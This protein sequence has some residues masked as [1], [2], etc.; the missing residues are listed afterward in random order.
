MKRLSFV[1]ILLLVFTLL[2]AGCGTKDEADILKSLEKKMDELDGYKAN[3]LLSI[4]TG[5][6]PQ[7]YDVEI[8]YKE[9]DFYRIALNNKEREI[10]QI[11]LK[12]EDGVFVLTP[13]LNKSFR[14]QSDWPDNQGQVYLY[15][16]LVKS[17][18]DDGERKFLPEGNVYSFEVNA[19]YQN[20]NLV[21]QKIWLNEDGLTP[22]KVEIMDADGNVLVGLE[23]N[24]FQFTSDF[25]KDSFDN[26]RNMTSGL[27]RSVPAM[28]Q[29]KPK[30]S[31]GVIIP[32]YT[33]DGVDLVEQKE[34]TI[35][36]EP[37]VVLKF[38]G[39]YNYSLVE[40]RPKSISV[41]LPYGT[42][43]D[44]GPVIGVMSLNGKPSLTW[45]YDGVDYLLSGDLPEVEMVSIAKSVFGQ[46]G[47]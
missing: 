6:T 7:Q 8:W 10:T 41:S 5:N 3:A 19:N 23:F 2:L 34:V 4:N 13:H 1:F 40:E 20:R 43:V 37:S 38:K 29:E 44:L 18:F 25:E 45:T 42:P 31:F 33:P 9:P 21:K 15:Q 14:F 11:I 17:I 32:S 27:L 24:D 36:G 16:S 22:A 12:N 47:K 30:G 39:V 35:D 26:E 28:A 46:T